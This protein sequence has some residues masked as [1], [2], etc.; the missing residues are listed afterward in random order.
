MKYI[1]VIKKINIIIILIFIISIVFANYSQAV[2]N[3]FSDAD[4]FLGERRTN[5]SYYR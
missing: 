1:N 4:S 3:I 2:G 5:I